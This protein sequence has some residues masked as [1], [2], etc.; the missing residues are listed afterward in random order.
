MISEWPLS[1]VR[2]ALWR[3]CIGKVH[4]TTVRSVPIEIVI[5]IIVNIARRHAIDFLFRVP[6]LLF[7]R[8]VFRTLSLLFMAATG[9]EERI[10]LL[11][12][13]LWRG[14]L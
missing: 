2:T 11:L 10:L 12:S 6:D 14:L 13:C 9:I 3:S 5:I 7:D 4:D 8:K 1:V